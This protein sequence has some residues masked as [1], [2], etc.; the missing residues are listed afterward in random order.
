LLKTHLLAFRHRDKALCLS[1][2]EKRDY[3][4]ISASRQLLFLP[5]LP[6]CCPAIPS[7][8]LARAPENTV[9][10]GLSCAPFSGEANYSK[11]PFELASVFAKNLIV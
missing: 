3:A 1:A 10:T 7:P 6:I 2:T 11:A 8:R 5:K 9:S 4:A